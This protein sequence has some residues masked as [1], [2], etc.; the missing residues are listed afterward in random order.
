MAAVAAGTAGAAVIGGVVAAVSK[1]G[2]WLKDVGRQVWSLFKKLGEWFMAGVKWLGARIRDA[3]A[4]AKDAVKH[5][6]NFIA[7]VLKAAWDWLKGVVPR[8]FAELMK[9]IRWYMR[10]LAE[11]PEVGLTATLLFLYLLS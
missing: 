9:L 1:I 5:L 11:K 6:V 10:M 8:I 2:D 3:M 4:G 7:R